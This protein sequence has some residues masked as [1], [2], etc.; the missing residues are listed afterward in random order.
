MKQASRGRGCCPQ[1][2]RYLKTCEL[3]KQDHYL[4]ALTF[5]AE[6][7]DNFSAKHT[8]DRLLLYPLCRA[9]PCGHTAPAAESHPAAGL[10]ERPTALC[11]PNLGS[12]PSRCL[13]QGCTPA[14]TT[15]VFFWQRRMLERPF[16]HRGRR[17]LITK[18]AHP[19]GVRNETA[20]SH[21]FFCVCRSHSDTQASHKSV[22]YFIRSTCSFKISS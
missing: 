20:F 15:D 2:K 1:K 21:L 3:L 22:Y 7:T 16:Y 12:C 18:A 8:H 13:G 11:A 14:S 6:R 19:S 17:N 10:L 9:E 5:L 4:S